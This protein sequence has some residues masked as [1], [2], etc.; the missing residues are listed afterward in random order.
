MKTNIYSTREEL[1]QFL[2][3]KGFSLD[4]RSNKIWSC[5]SYDNIEISFNKGLM[6]SVRVNNV[7]VADFRQPLLDLEIRPNKLVITTG[8]N[9]DSDWANFYISREN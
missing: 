5:L 3:S 1:I 9:K 2:Q 6:A 8:T 7:L 4:L